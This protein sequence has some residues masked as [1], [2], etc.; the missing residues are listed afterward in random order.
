MIDFHIRDAESYDYEPT[1]PAAF[2]TK[3]NNSP[4]SELTD[5]LNDYVKPLLIFYAYKR[6]LV[7]QGRNITQYSIVTPADTT[8]NPISDQS[9]AVLIND[10]Q[11]KIAICLNKHN[12]ELDDNNCTFDGVIYDFTGIKRQHGIRINKI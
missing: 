12:K 4:A 6:F 5:F 8:S 10:I 3:L 9:R 11:S 2:W 1:V 7:W